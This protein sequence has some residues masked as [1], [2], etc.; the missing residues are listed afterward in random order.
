MNSAV[1]GL[2]MQA[3]CVFFD[4]NVPFEDAIGSY[5]CSLEANM[6]VANGI[7][8]GCLLLLPVDAVNPVETCQATPITFEM[9]AACG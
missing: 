5:A 2:P 7:P 3:R 1:L 4:K 9:L 6:R 8:L